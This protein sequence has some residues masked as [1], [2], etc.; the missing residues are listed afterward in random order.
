MTQKRV[1][2]VLLWDGTHHVLSRDFNRHQ[3]TGNLLEFAKRLKVWDVDEIVIL[4]ISSYRN[5]HPFRNNISDLTN[6]CKLVREVSENCFAPL[7]VGGGIR[8]IREIHS[9]F[10]SGADRVLLNSSTHRN[11][12]IVSNAAKVFGSQAIIAGIDVK[13]EG[14]EHVVYSEGRTVPESCPPLEWARTLQEAGAGEILLQSIDRDGTTFGYDLPIIKAMRNVIDI[15]LMALGGAGTH[16][17][18]RLAIEAGADAAAAAN[19]FTF[20]ELSY[21]KV[22]DAITSKVDTRSSNF[23]DFQAVKR[24]AEKELSSASKESALWNML[25]ETGLMG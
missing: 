17:D 12:E 22:K 9:I 16:D 5:S 21:P 2:P 4:N 15:P 3:R 7:I 24:K 19:L 14:H 11:I 6:L 23:F 1:T 18:F 20:S 10:Q 13:L 25:D 8:D